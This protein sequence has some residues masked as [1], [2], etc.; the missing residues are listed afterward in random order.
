MR[1]SE[2]AEFYEQSRDRCLRAAVAHGMQPDRAED[3]VAEAYAKAWASWGKVRRCKAPAAWVVRTAINADISRWRRRRREVLA[4][5]PDTVG[6]WRDEDGVD[7]VTAI[8]SLPVRQRE[9]IVLHYLLDLDVASTARYLGLATG[10][11][12]AYL[13]AARNELRVK[14]TPEKELQK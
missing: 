1:A 11:V 8:R 6:L 2:F 12:K 14:L 3:A 4:D 10:T 5:P 13:H 9:V 7:L